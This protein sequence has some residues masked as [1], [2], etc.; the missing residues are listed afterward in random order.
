MTSMGL[1]IQNRS[2]IMKN[3]IPQG[4]YKNPSV[5]DGI[6]DAIVE[7]VTTGKY[8]ENNVCAE[9]TPSSRGSHRQARFGA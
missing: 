1:V 5:K 2:F 7:R 3:A 9:R 8:G 4:P 6:Y